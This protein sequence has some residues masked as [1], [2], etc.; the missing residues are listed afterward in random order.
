ME[1]LWSSLLGSDLF[2]LPKPKISRATNS[3]NQRNGIAFAP[4]Q[5]I[6]EDIIPMRKTSKQKT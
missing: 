3:I 1:L 6:F 5:H 4:A 2:V